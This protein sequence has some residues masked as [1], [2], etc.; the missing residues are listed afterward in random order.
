MSCISESGLHGQIELENIVNFMKDNRLNDEYAA[1]RCIRSSGT[2][3]CVVCRKERGD[4]MAI[5]K[6]AVRNH[7]RGFDRTGDDPNERGLK[8]TPD[9]VARCMR[10]YL[11]A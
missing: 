10:K 4:T 2:A 1:N 5:D 6:D 8:D 11:K 3:K 7:I 9:R